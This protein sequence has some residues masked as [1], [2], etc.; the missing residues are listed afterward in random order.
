MIAPALEENPTV[1][2]V[3][4]VHK[5]F[6]SNHVLKGIS[7]DFK[8]GTTTVILGGSGSGK[9]VLMKHLIGLLS[10]D[11]GQVFV[12][13]EDISNL[14]GQGLND[15][16]MKFGMVFQWA[17]LFDSMNVYE[18]VAFPLREHEP[19][20]PEAEVKERVAQKLALFG[21]QGIEEKNPADLSG[22]M[23]KRVGLARAIMMNPRIVLY[24]EPTTG[25]DP[26][27][28]KY[29]DDMI[30]R[31]KRELKVTSVVISHDIASAFNVADYIAFLYEGEIVEYGTPSQLRQS[32][33]PF[34]SEFLD[35][36]FGRQ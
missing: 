8:E 31:A 25:L 7:L 22:G 19:N 18:N 33:H 24:D 34:V 15:L 13:G 27:T 21:L 36:W 3:K 12:D 10:P 11:E 17:A 20:L 30:L 6:G 14:R 2:S 28:T 23:R 35:T 1:M 16:R 4:N 26:I 9:T 5:R 29:V 32:K